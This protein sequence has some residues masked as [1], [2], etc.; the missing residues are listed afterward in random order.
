MQM[1]IM[2]YTIFFVVSYCA[3]SKLEGIMENLTI[4]NFGIE[5][6]INRFNVISYFSIAIV[7]IIP[8]ILVFNFINSEIDFMVRKMSTYTLLRY[9][10]SASFIKVV[11]K[12]IF[13]QVIVY[14]LILLVATV[15]NNSYNFKL[16]HILFFIFKTICLIILYFFISIKLNNFKYLQGFFLI[17]YIIF[18]LASI[19][20]NNVILKELFLAV[21][22]YLTILFWVIL[23]LILFENILKSCRKKEY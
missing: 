1:K 5:E 16:D 22:S 3:I 4:F 8:S 9:Q 17:A 13:T 2:K 6:F 15:L 12:D 18:V 20:S 21:T 11:I 10:S 19:I 7:W 23:S 14:T